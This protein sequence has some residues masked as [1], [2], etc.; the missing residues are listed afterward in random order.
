MH[1]ITALLLSS[2]PAFAYEEVHVVCPVSPGASYEFRFDATGASPASV[3][4][5]LPNG[6]QIAGGRIFKIGANRF[7]FYAEPFT[8]RFDRDTW[9][10]EVETP[11]GLDMEDPDVATYRCEPNPAFLSGGA[12]I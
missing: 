4:L 8:V 12:G 2:V 7:H 1:F 10:A 9:T 3:T 5:K 11:A 6:E